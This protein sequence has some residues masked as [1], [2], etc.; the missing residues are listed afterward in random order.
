MPQI[1]FQY[2]LN[3]LHIVEECLELVFLQPSLSHD[4]IDPWYEVI[5][6]DYLMYL[7]YRIV[8]CESLLNVHN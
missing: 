5:D 4:T 7:H 1:N 3:L 2:K 8:F 6:N